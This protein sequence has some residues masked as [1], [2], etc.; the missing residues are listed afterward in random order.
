MYPA[1]ILCMPFRSTILALA[2]IVLLSVACSDSGEQDCTCIEIDVRDIAPCNGPIVPY[3]CQ[4]NPTVPRY[5][6]VDEP[7]VSIVRDPETGCDM[8]QFGG[9]CGECCGCQPRISAE[10]DEYTVLSNTQTE[11]DV[12][13][14]DRWRID[15]PSQLP[16]ISISLQPDHGAANVTV[17]SVLYTP[18][19]D[20]TGN[21]YFQYT[22]EIDGDTSTASVYLDIITTSVDAGTED[23]S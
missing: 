1:T 9:N 11:L 7:C 17:E 12:L 14:N 2:P 15:Y 20:H 8:P 4:E 10:D 6:I 5:R 23:G 16:L 19:I 21:D 3:G 13:E 22:V 18:D